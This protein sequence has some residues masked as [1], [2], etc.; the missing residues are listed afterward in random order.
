MDKVALW[1]ARLAM[2][3]LSKDQRRVIAA[4]AGD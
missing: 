4:E 2:K 3:T 1:H